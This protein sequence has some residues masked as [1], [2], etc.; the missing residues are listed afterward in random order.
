MEELQARAGAAR[1]SHEQLEALLD[2]VTAVSANLELPLV[3]GR[4]V[5]S[6]CALVNARYGALG[7]LSPDGEHLVE[8]VTHGISP[9]E[10]ARIGD[11]P[12]GHGILGLLI[13]DPRPRRLADISAHPDSYG[14]PPNHPPMHSFLGA[15]IRIRDEV[16]G[17][18]YL[19]ERKGGG[20]FTQSDEAM[21]VALASGGID[22]RDN[23]REGLRA[24]SP[25]GDGYAVVDVRPVQVV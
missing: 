20:E 24:K 13:R 2:A 17:N 1:R 21:L 12:R 7:V 6:A 3:L 25:D 23:R 11:L 4:I 15:P 8:F 9:E 10:R 14:F 22:K 5:R 19:A 16:F 18:L